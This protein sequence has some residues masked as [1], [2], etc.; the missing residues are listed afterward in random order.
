MSDTRLNAATTRT[1]V[2][3]RTIKQPVREAV[4]EVLVERD[5][6]DARRLEESTET[7]DPSTTADDSSSNTS[8]ETDDEDEGD[9]SGRVSGR[10]LVVLAGVLAGVAYAVSRRRGAGSDDGDGET[11]E[12]GSVSTDAGDP[13][14]DGERSSAPAEDVTSD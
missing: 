13:I 8:E 14:G 6:A 1:S 9:S 3:E 5:L 10:R 2:F 4:R 7:D 11:D 12:E